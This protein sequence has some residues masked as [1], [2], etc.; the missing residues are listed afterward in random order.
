MAPAPRRPRIYFS[1]RS[2]YSWLAFHDLTTRRPQLVDALE[3][4]P[5][6]EPDEHSERLL[7]E[8]G[9][10]FPYTPMSREKHLYM[11]TDVRRL[12][13]RRG[14]APTWPRDT[15]PWW[16]ASHLA[17]LVAVGEGRGLAFIDRVYR[18]RW[19]E[20]LDISDRATVGRLAA[21]VG[22]DPKTAENAAD[23]ERIRAEGVRAL[24]DIHRD[25]VFGVPF[26][27]HRRQKFWGVDRL[28][29]FLSV[30]GELGSPEP[31]PAE[32]VPAPASVAAYD[33]SSSDLG[34]AGGCG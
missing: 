28:E 15:D 31:A 6:W 34:H 23:D 14:L 5:F 24:L 17:Y 10:R 11:L 20:G 2:P 13:T 32:P 9:G 7:A 21:D 25:D 1:F 33:P 22:V 27:I 18:A 8:A 3:W 30:L 26:F 29:E 4:R 12:A 19:Q 16:E